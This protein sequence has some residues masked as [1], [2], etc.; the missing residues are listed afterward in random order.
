M[1]I[2]DEA[3]R[4]IVDNAGQTFATV[5]GVEFQYDIVGS[6]VV[7]RHTHYPLHRSQFDI[8]AARWPVTGPGKLNRIVRGPA[9]IFA[10]LSDPRI[11]L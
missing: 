9:Y 5:R 1:T 4:R 7:P 10:I 8:A 6:T 11:G 3:W 2:F